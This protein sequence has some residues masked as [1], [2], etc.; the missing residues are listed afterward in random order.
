M[1]ELTIKATLG[2]L[3]VPADFSQRLTT[4]GLILLSMTPPSTP[5]QSGTSPNWP[6]MT[7]S[8][9]CWRHRPPTRDSSC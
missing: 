6:G 7:R 2:K 4:Q 8:T 1:W 5:R 3:S 9:A